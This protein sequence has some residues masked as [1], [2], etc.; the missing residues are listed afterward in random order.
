[1]EFGNLGDNYHI[2]LKQLNGHGR[3][4]ISQNNV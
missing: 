2:R 3:S 4:I 1:M